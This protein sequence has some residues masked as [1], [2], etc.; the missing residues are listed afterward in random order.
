M[1]AAAEA[2]VTRR[3]EF[4]PEAQ[5]NSPVRLLVVPAQ[6]GDRLPWPLMLVVAAVVLAQLDPRLRDQVAEPLRAVLEVPAFLVRSRDPPPFM[7]VAVV[8]ALR[9]VSR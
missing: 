1:V 4:A 6:A 8:V 3:V 7:Q 5:L 9:S 2:A